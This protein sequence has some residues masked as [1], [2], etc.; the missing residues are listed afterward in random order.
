[1]PREPDTGTHPLSS[2]LTLLENDSNSSASLDVYE[3]LHVLSIVKAEGKFS[4]RISLG[5]GQQFPSP[6]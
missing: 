3:K 1:M 6:H 5:P 4:R 2:P